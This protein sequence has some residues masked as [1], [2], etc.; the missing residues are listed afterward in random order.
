MVQGFSGSVVPNKAEA[1]KFEISGVIKKT[2]ATHLEIT[3]IPIRKW[4]QDY[5]E[6]LE[7]M[8]PGTTKT[9]ESAG[10]T[11]EDFREY[12]TENSVHFVVTLTEAKMK[13]A[14]Q[15]GLEKI[16]KLK[17]SV[18]IQ[19]MVLFDAEGKI[20]KYDSALD[21]LTEFCKVR[22]TLYEKRKD[23]LVCSLTKDK[24]ILSNKARFI[25]MIVNEELEIRKKKKEVLLKELQKLKFT[26]MCELNAIMK[27]KDNR[28]ETKKKKDEDEDGDENEEA[29]AEKSDYDYLLGMNLWSLT[30][31]K[32]DEIK[33][34]L[35]IKED[36]LKELKK[37]TIEQFWDLDLDALA[38]CLDEMDLAD[39][40]DAEAA[41]E[42]AELRQRKVKGKRGPAPAGNVVKKRV[43]TR[44][45]NKLLSAP[46]VG[47]AADSLGPVAKEI[48]GT[49]ENGP[50]RFSAADIPLE[51]QQMVSRDPD[52]LQRP[53][54][55]PRAARAPRA[56]RTADA[57]EEE[58]QASSPPPAEEPSGG[59]LLARLLAGRSTPS[60][61]TSSSG[62]SGSHGALST[63]A[64]FFFGSSSSLFS[65]G[66]PEPDDPAPAA[67]EAEPPAKKAKKAGKPKKKGADDDDEEE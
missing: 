37:K 27:G 1:G 38:A 42:A 10:H 66:L 23:Y 16:F 6:F 52:T 50:T 8:M 36:E 63:G 57:G 5:K 64:D 18:S 53:A 9:E 65:S 61:G 62:G 15:A 45:E 67:A 39:D 12:H 54:K 58:T 31:E 46:L 21:I 14:E 4:T 7:G 13:E 3:E 11:I 17:T 51:D 33:K 24:E 48:S 20:A 34:Q 22:R 59:S 26:P 55:A 40:K 47:N 35:R 30:Q 29:A 44:D 32:V 41:R 60:L 28:K 56:P 2:D 19:N 25:L 49:G 43:A